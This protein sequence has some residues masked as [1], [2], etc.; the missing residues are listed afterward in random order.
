MGLG[1]SYGQFA[2]Q[3][4]GFVSLAVIEQATVGVAPGSIYRV[5]AAEEGRLH[6]RAVRGETRV[7]GHG[8]TAS[9]LAVG[10]PIPRCALSLAGTLIELF[11][12]LNLLVQRFT[13]RGVAPSR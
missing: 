11:V 8:P 1:L 9:A 10:P 6:P 2:P 13:R 3:Q 4:R 12:D 7:T 5:F